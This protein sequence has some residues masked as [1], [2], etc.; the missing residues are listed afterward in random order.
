VSSRIKWLLA[1][2]GILVLVF[3]AYNKT[4]SEDYRF[5]WDDNILLTDNEMIK[6]SDGLYRFWFTADAYDYFPVTWS[7]LW[8]EWR[9]WG[10]D[11][12]GYHLVSV[13]Q[14]ALGAILLYAL[15]R[16]LGIPGAY[17]AAVIFAVHPVTVMSV[18]W[19]SERKNT[20][21]LVFYLLT[22]LL[23]LRFDEDR[24]WPW[25]ALSLGMFLLA[26]L[27]KTSGV[28][29]PVVL[30]L[31]AWW[32]RGRVG[33]ADGLAAAPFFILAAGMSAVTIWFQT[34]RS[35]GEAPVRPEGF[36]SRLAAAGCVPWFYLYKV[37]LPVNLLVIYPRWQIDE[38]WALSYLPGIAFLA[39]L[40]IFWK[41]RHSWGRPLFFGLGYFIVMLFPVL[42]F[43]PMAFAEFSFVSDHLQ[44]LPMIGV[45]ALLVGIG[46]WA[47]QRLALPVRAVGAL[48]A[49]VIV[50][51]LALGTSKH[52]DTFK[53][54]DTMWRTQLLKRPDSPTAYYNLGLTL[55]KSGRI[56]QAAAYYEKAI[57][58]K[59]QYS[60]A[61]N[62]LARICDRLGQRE[63]AL[64][65]FRQAVKYKPDN[66]N[67]RFN[68][69]MRLSEDG[70]YVEAIQG[71]HEVL[72]RAPDWS[73]PLTF[74]AKLLATVP[75]AQLRDGAEALRLAKRAVEKTEKVDPRPIQPLVA[76]A[77]AY[78]ETGD[79]SSAVQVATRAMKLA[80]QQ[81]R[82]RLAQDIHRQIAGY[83]GGQ[84]LRLIPYA[85]TTQTAQPPDKTP[86]ANT[87]A[88]RP[89]TS[90]PAL[91]P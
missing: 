18:A 48:V 15:L 29:L 68:L 8:L 67:A 28:M 65:H 47:L 3:A 83:R 85:A 80:E 12:R 13:L 25:Y 50:V 46:W 6:A 7:S 43:F 9:L 56:Y 63:K 52:C 31:L 23:Y 10:E 1:A 59:P 84:P 38:T 41:Y 40:G 27:S 79:F 73:M 32:R 74:L 44:Y 42:G 17:L 81:G 20:L 76:L 37:V 11:P 34:V 24:R 45:V 66:L 30:L 69:A 33:L 53:D 64:Y 89:A 91:G 39:C 36:L 22:V 75:D 90:S 49:I 82:R 57:A 35:I 54:R 16:R 5:V 86:P 77:A 88:S 71:Y 61:H 4:L 62:N 55:E 19:I 14:H 70:E 87:P 72:E 26:L 58:L 78:A 21:S 51:V 2:G 60:Q